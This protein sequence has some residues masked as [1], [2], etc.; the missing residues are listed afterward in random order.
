MQS[1]SPSPRGCLLRPLSLGLSTCETGVLAHRAAPGDSMGVC[2]NALCCPHLSLVA[3]M[4]VTE[5]GHP[6]HLL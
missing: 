2:C 3:Q 1:P 5:E 4:A 6:V